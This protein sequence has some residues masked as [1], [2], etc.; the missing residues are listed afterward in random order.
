[1]AERRILGIDPGSRAMGFG[2]ISASGNRI[3]YI[4]AGVVRPKTL[5]P[6]S[7]R[8][9][10]LYQGISEVISQYSPSE[11]SIEQVFVA[12]NAKAA[13]K[14]GHARAAAL[15][16]ALNGGLDLFE[17]TPLEIKKA[18]SGYGQAEKE[19]VRQMVKLLLGLDKSPAMDA[20]DALAAAICH[21]NSSAMRIRL[22]LA[23]SNR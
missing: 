1:M 6:F 9:M 7:Y 3:R 20:S 22:N 10:E 5:E 14:L 11:A 16:S 15:L 8:L 13:L 19:Q 23:T 12:R 17:Y 18:V 21:A 2:V 4:A